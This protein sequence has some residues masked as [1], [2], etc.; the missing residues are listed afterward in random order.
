MAEAVL[1]HAILDHAKA[2]NAVF[3]RASLRDASLKEIEAQGAS[4]ICAMLNGA[5]LSNGKFGTQGKPFSPD[6]MP[7]VF[8]GASC[9]D[10]QALSADF[11]G[12]NLQGANGKGAHFEKATLENANLSNGLFAAT[13]FTQAKISGANEMPSADAVGGCRGCSPN[14]SWVY[15]VRGQADGQAENGGGP[16]QVTPSQLR[17]LAA[18]RLRYV[19]VDQRVRAIDN[20]HGYGFS[21]RPP[22]GALDKLAHA[23]A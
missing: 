21:V 17:A 16:R 22:G 10:A 18:Q 19:A 4:F 12:V 5:D 3:T 2:Q 11:Y 23:V 1:D 15:R 7:A 9:E 6:G 8:A 13:E 20:A 14:P